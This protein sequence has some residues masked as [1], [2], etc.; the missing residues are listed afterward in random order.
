MTE[1]AVKSEEL[2]QCCLKRVTGIDEISRTKILRKL[3]DGYGDVKRI[4]NGVL[5]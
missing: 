3:E 2:C 1:I 5:V 4:T